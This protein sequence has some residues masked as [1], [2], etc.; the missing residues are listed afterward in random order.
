MLYKKLLAVILAFVLALS[1]FAC[2]GTNNENGNTGGTSSAGGS[3]SGGSSETGD[4]GSSGGNS[5]GDGTIGEVTV[6]ENEHE[7]ELVSEDGGT[8]AFKCANCEET[9]S[10]TVT[11]T[12]GTD[13]AYSLSG[14]ELTF[15]GITEDSEYSLSGEFY[16][17]IVIDAGDDYKFGL[18][19]NGF[20][21]TSYKQCP[22]A[23]TSGDKLS[24]SAKKGS[25]NFVYDYRDEATSDDEISSA[26]YAACDLNVQGKGELTVISAHNNGVH[27]KDDLKIKNLTLTVVCSDNA[28]K[29]NDSVT[30]ESG[31]I[32]LTANAGD[33]IKTKNSD[34][35]SKGN[36][37]GIVT[38]SGGTVT[39]YAA[40][41]GID[42]AYDVVIKGDAIVNIYT[43]DYAK[44]GGASTQSAD[45][46]TFLNAQGV[47]EQS[48]DGQGAKNGNG[49][50]G[51]PNGGA[52]NGQGGQGGVPNGGATN[53]QGGQGGFPNGGQGGFPNGGANNGQ[54]GQGGF[55]NGGQGGQGSGNTNKPDYS[56]KGIKSAND[57]AVSGGTVTVKATDD[58]IHANSGEEL[59]NGETSTGNVTV[60]GGSLTLLSGDDAIHADGSVLVSGGTITVTACYEGLEGETVEIAGGNVSVVSSDDGL[61]GTGVSGAS[62]KISGGELFVLA[63]GDAL[64][65]NSRTSYGGIVFSGGKAVVVSY[66]QA[67]SAIDTENGYSYTGGYVL[68]IGL[69]AGMNGDESA[70]AQNF[71]SVGTTK[72]FNLSAGSFVTAAGY[73]TLKMPRAMNALAVFLG[74]KS[75]S[76]SSS[77]SSS[78]ALNADGVCWNV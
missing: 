66:G 3:S 55:P 29:G 53:G 14:D 59:E 24:V 27:T 57:I 51:F 32:T 2:G 18:E 67:D 10:F 17:N 63:G 1:L 73:V 68:A 72:T 35:S 47:I 4:S 5:D 74:D 49:F 38:V 60:S 37:R 64:D 48:F 44:N 50:G 75:A 36:Q 56:A 71:G 7:Y 25:E 54:G 45:S 15:S 12:S 69:S 40:R 28:L 8:F 19:L 6:P 70:K 61:N 26:V 13:G 43:D 52:N 9:T 78:A 22:I 20:T 11:L 16:G 33:G 65:S 76:L 46:L 77:S 62:I 31:V 39:I 21:I 41:D 42:A 58:A 23:A 30:I 34:V